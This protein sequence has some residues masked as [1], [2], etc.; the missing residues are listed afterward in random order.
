MQ[1]Y[2]SKNVCPVC[3]AT[4]IF[5]A[6]GETEWETC[7]NGQEHAELRFRGLRSMIK[8]EISE[9]TTQQIV[10]QKNIVLEML[11]ILNQVG[12]LRAR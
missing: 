8:N 11:E 5:H 4:L 3:G 6:Q 1:E 9:M 10:D 2:D 12:E 7:P